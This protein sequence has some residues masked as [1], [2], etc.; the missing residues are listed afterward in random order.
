MLKHTI[1]NI[2]NKCLDLLLTDDEIQTAFARAVD[3]DNNKHIDMNKCCKCWPINSNDE[4]CPFWKSIFGL[5]EH[6]DDKKENG[7]NG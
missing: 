1:I 7:C 4:C 3:P 5:C 2:D 6:C